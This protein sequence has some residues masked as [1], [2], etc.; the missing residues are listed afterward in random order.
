MKHYSVRDIARRPSL[1][2]I[3]PDEMVFIEDRKLHKMLGLYIGSDLAKEFADFLRHKKLIA[4]AEKIKASASRE[5][6]AFEG[7]LDDGL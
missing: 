5:N 6:E 4:A 2:R 3:A 1:L 7:T